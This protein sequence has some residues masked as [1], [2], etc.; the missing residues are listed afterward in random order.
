MKPSAGTFLL[1]VSA[2]AC[3]W[4]MGPAYA[5]SPAAFPATRSEA[6]AAP[7]E[8]PPAQS[9]STASLSKSPDTNTQVQSTQ[10][11]GTNISPDIR[12][13]HPRVKELFSQAVHL[14][15]INHAYQARDLLEQA[16]ALAPKSAGIHCNLGLAYQNSGNIPRA[17]EEFRAALALNP[18][19]PEATLNLAG[20]YQSMGANTEAI[21]WYR[22]YLSAKEIAEPQ[23]KQINDIIA[24]LENAVQ[25]PYSDPKGEDY[26]ANVT[27]EGTYR[28]AKE[29]M[30]IRVFVQNA[31]AL[32]SKAPG[33]YKEAFKSALLGAFDRWCQATGNRVKYQV[34][35]DKEHADIFCTWTSD[36]MEV[37]ENG[38]LSERGSAK[39]IVKGSQIERATL[40]IL[41]RP[42][43]ED[44]VLSE[45]EMK[46]A[47][48]HE[49]GHVLGLQGHSTN[50]HDVMFFTVD[51]ATVWPV[52]SR[53]DK[54]TILR[55]Y[56]SYPVVNAKP[57]ST[58]NSTN[59]A[60]QPKPKP[61]AK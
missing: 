37:T 7:V 4:V 41:T 31:D 8:T 28:W 19:M 23:R 47:C 5:D 45:D 12:D 32:N 14:L 17:L 48:L 49:V 43:L 58:A 40:K 57:I 51:T 21:Y 26:L 10:S 1:A 54:A 27:A 34:V 6:P 46:K 18:R 24:A 38:T 13:D 42:I 53:R 60:T 55:L 16:V 25:K 39:I 35:P 2:Y 11:V 3:A 20:C 36:P 44:G 15:K 22:S 56:Q 52:L 29:K 30:P 61:R 59:S 9:E 50:N 33:G